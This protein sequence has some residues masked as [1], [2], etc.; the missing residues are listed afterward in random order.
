MIPKYPFIVERTY[1]IGKGSAPAREARSFETMPPCVALRDEW[2]RKP[3]TRT[4]RIM[5]ILDETT[6]RDA[7]SE[8][9]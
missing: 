2:H 8:Q 7:R 5:C 1:S 4:V 6:A 9:G 3:A